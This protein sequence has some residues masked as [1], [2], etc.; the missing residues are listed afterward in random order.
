MSANPD[1]ISTDR[2]NFIRFLAASPLMTP[3]GVSAIVGGLTAASG[4]AFAQSYDVLRAPASKVGDV[5][6]SPDQAL[7]VMDFEPA[8]K[9][10]CPRPITAI[11]RRAST[12]TP[13]CSPIT[14]PSRSCASGCGG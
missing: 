13:R 12:T 11:W 3:A 8:A 10:A 5:I 4:A 14:T 2:R 6:A 9:Q 7:E 1:R